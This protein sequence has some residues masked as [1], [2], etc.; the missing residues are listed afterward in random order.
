MVLTLAVWDQRQM[1]SCDSADNTAGAQAVNLWS[2]LT[3]LVYNTYILMDT[4]RLQ[5]QST[6]SN[7]QP[8][9]VANT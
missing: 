3:V 5:I 9:Q 4:F 8:A 6:S 1:Q 7:C 2:T